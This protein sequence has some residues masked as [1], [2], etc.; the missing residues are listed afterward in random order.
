MLAD[1]A[2]KSP[3]I[4]FFGGYAAEATVI[5]N[6][7][8]QS[9]LQD[10]ILFGGDGIYG[11]DFIDRTKENGEGNVCFRNDKELIGPGALHQDGPGS[12]E[13]SG[14]SDWTRYTPLR[15]RQRLDLV[16]R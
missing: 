14:E 15:G 16:C 13:E 6:Q 12:G 5:V 7:M 2:S 11:T 3:E 4:I 1:V 9:G 10:A 8:D